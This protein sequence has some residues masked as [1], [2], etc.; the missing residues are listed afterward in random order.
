MAEADRECGDSKM[1]WEA[2]GAESKTAA[3]ASGDRS[4]G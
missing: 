1:L 2:F 3:G 4:A